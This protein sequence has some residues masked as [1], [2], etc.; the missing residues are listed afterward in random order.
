VAKLIACA[1]GM[2]LRIAPGIDGNDPDEWI[3]EDISGTD[4]PFISIDTDDIGGNS[5]SLYTFADVV[6]I[7]GLMLIVGVVAFA[8]RKKAQTIYRGR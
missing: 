7:W 5:P 8:V 6:E 1:D 2:N 4:I 3:C